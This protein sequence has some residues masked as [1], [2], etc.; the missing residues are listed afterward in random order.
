METQRPTPTLSLFDPARG[1]AYAVQ[2]SP[3]VL[4]RE[5]DVAPWIF[6]DKVSRHHGILSI[7]D[8]C[9][10]FTHTGAN[11]TL[12]ISKTHACRLLPGDIVPIAHGDILRLAD[13]ML[14]VLLE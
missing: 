2:G 1:V 10:T 6:S 3:I 14:V 7:T 8:G 4:G 5:G 11:P 13:T 9:W 12:L